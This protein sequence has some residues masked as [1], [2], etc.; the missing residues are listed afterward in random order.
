VYYKVKNSWGDKSNDCGGYFFASEAFVRM[1][2]INLLMH[3][4]ALS[5]EVKKAWQGRK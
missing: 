3:K 2:T 1:H 4:D 5:S